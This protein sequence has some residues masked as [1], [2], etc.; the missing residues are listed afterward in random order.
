MT[1]VELTVD[2]HYERLKPIVWRRLRSGEQPRLDY[3]SFEDRYQDV[4]AGIA[5]S[6]QSGRPVEVLPGREVRYLT[7]A[8][9]RSLIDSLRADRRGVG[10]AEK[11][12]VEVVALD[13]RLDVA[14]PVEDSRHRA[15]LSKLLLLARSRLTRREAQVFT[16]A[17]LHA[18]K[19]S[20][21][22]EVLGCSVETV[23]T[24]RKAAAR[25]IGE[26][27]IHAILRDGFEWC[28]TEEADAIRRAA[29]GGD[30][31]AERALRHHLRQCEVCSHAVVDMRRTAA[32]VAPIP[33]L[34][35]ATG[36][37]A[38]ALLEPLRALRDWVA[39]AVRRLGTSAV[40]GPAATKAV[41]VV[42]S[43]AAVAGGATAIDRS[44]GPADAARRSPVAQHVTPPAPSPTPTA[45]PSQ[46]ISRSSPKPPR[47]RAAAT[48]TP[49]S[50]VRK[51]RASSIAAA[52]PKSTGAHPN[53]GVADREQHRTAPGATDF[54]FER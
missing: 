44:T 39:D 24:H 45:A 42:A 21:S 9:M 25:K 29:I 36:G 3:D 51:T 16:L 38:A 12:A 33:L 6:G 20:E 47:K 37:S 13:D 49:D 22:A 52:S 8:V 34:L 31:A 53:D 15:A 4:W 19:P 40:H 54:T 26:Q 35:T 48:R 17:Y 27:L 50:H 46:R 30:E 5:A 28:A 41:A 14:A 43:T 2:V 11:P 18:M 32:A 10:R 7:S 23:K 1:M